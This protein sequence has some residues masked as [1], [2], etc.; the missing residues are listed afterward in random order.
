MFGLLKRLAS[1]LPSLRHGVKPP[2]P[3]TPPPPQVPSGAT[4]TYG[5]P[6]RVPN[7]VDSSVFDHHYPLRDSRRKTK[8]AHDRSLKIRSNRRKAAR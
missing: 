6:A 4:R 5:L 7:I 2:P 1:L 8:G 3:T